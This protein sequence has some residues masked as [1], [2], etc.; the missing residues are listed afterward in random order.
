MGIGTY[1]TYLQLL[2]AAPEISGMWGIAPLP[3]LEKEDGT[4]DRSSASFLALGDVI[5]SN[6]GN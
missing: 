4:V 1:A 3:G 6:T 5:L 2:T